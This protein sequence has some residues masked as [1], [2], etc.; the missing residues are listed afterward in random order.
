MFFGPNVSSLDP[1]TYYLLLT[2]YYL[3]LTTY[4]L[5]LTTYYLLLTTYY[6]LLTT[7]YRDVLW[8]E[9]EQLGSASW[10]VQGARRSSVRL[11]QT[12]PALG[13]T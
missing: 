1:T 12:R 3:P 11:D 13:D 10:E 4:Y 7:Y 2:T 9:C 8:T 5:L 6:S